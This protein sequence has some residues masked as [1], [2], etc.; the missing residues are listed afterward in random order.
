MD[1]FWWE[2]D[3]RTFRITHTLHLPQFIGTRIESGPDSPISWSGHEEV[4]RE[5][6]LFGDA[7]RV[8]RTEPDYE[9][10]KVFG[11]GGGP[12]RLL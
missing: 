9:T 5:I 1:I 3:L 10:T 6:R 7:N 2:S 11:T 12:T 8:L 4:R